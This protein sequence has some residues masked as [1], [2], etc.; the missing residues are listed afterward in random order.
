MSRSAT[1]YENKLEPYLSFLPR[2]RWDLGSSFSGIEARMR[3]GCGRE[4]TRAWTVWEINEGRVKPSLPCPWC[5][6]ESVTLRT[7]HRNNPYLETLK[8]R[9]RSKF[10]R[11]QEGNG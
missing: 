1:F 10:C 4:F 7:I 6:G 2:D 3:C 8:K 9:I 5:G 11:P